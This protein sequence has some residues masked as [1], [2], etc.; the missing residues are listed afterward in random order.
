MFGNLQ[1]HV[2]WIKK[3]H[4]Y[5]DV[6]LSRSRQAPLKLLID[7]ED[8]LDAADSTREQLSRSLR[9]V[10]DDSEERDEWL[11]SISWTSSPIPDAYF[12]L[13]ASLIQK[14]IGKDG[15]NMLRWSATKFWFPDDEDL[16]PR[17]QE[18]FN[19]STPRLERLFVTG[20]EY[21]S[22]GQPQF[23]QFLSSIPALS[24]LILS[25]SELLSILPPCP[26]LK[27]LQI[28]LDFDDYNSASF[29]L[30]KTFP[31]L[32]ELT[33]RS[34]EVDVDDEDFFLPI[35]HLPDLKILE[36]CGPL[37][38]NFIQAL[39]VKQL[40]KLVLSDLRDA[41]PIA[42]VC[43]VAQS[44][45]WDLEDDDDDDYEDDPLSD[46]LA[47]LFSQLHQVHTIAVPH[48]TR[49]DVKNAVTNCRARDQLKCLREIHTFRM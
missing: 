43:Q 37:P 32:D 12:S 13:C 45:E 14:L 9:G 48:D 20:R 40:G 44:L 5:L 11:D 10:I 28:S 6:H 18:L 17:I 30:I 24:E 33:L 42:H 27:K 41:T 35:I 1:D 49:E 29:H 2:A 34:D 47:T 7:F 22:D 31:L 39:R 36:L 46:V 26:S 16:A 23:Y 15:Q 4:L 38:R 3:Q 8:M 25:S 19:H 21:H